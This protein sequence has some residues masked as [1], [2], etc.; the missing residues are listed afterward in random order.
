MKHIKF[1]FGVRLGI[2]SALLSGG[3]FLAGC[4][5]PAAETALNEYVAPSADVAWTPPAGATIGT[6]P[7]AASVDIPENLLKPGAKWQLLDIIEVALQNSP[8][9]RSAWYSAR[10]AAADW[11]SK[12]GGNYPEING[13]AGIRRIDNL[14]ST[15]RTGPSETS[16]EPTLELSW[17]LFDFGGRKASVEEKRQALIVADF[18]HNATV[19][20][21]VFLVL[22]TYFEYASARALERA[23]ATSLDEAA[24]NLQAAQDRHQNG[25]AT[26]ADVLQAKTALSQAR[27]N[28]DGAQ[29]QVQ[30]IRGA[31]ATAM[32]IPA[33][34]ACDI[35]DL[36]MNPPVDRVSEAVED[37]IKRA[38]ENRP[39]LAAQKSRV[40]ESMAHIRTVRSA[41]YPSLV[42]SNT[43]GGTLDNQGAGFRADN[44]AAL[45]IVVP[46]FNGSSRR[47]DLF[48]AKQDANVQEAQLRSL[49]QSVILQVWSSYF[50]LKTSAQQVKTVEDLLASAAQSYEVALGRYK[51]GVGGLLDL[52]SAQS[53]LMDA[54]A[55]QVSAQADW[56]ISFSQLARDTGVLWSAAPEDNK[57]LL[58]TFPTAPVKEHQP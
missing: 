12:K 11:L 14:T 36:P 51:E 57:H 45:N 40:E 28:L 32:G 16:L 26:I 1:Y 52:L 39:D 23:L 49:E 5:H 9:T 29:G 48:K 58:D 10:S 44:T 56:Y 4:Y 6:E 21:Q 43:M 33:N 22:R 19:Q 47:Y 31:L 24:T 37:Y 46:L 30:T 41:I 35:E 2:L 53:A 55:R 34:T 18:I 7:K 20:D 13:G 15:N 54:R 8:E 17:L 42:L 38:E 50:S 27:L 25:L 3:F